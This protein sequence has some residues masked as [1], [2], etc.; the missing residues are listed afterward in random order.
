[1]NHE[2]EPEQRSE[3]ASDP[4][5]ERTPER[6]SGA[7]TEESY[8]TAAVL[9]EPAEHLFAAILGQRS[10]LSEELNEQ[11]KTLEPEIT[12]TD[13]AAPMIIDNVK[14]GQELKLNQPKA[15]GGKQDE[16]DGFIQDIQLY[17]AVNDNVYDSDKKKL[18]PS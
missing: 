10:P 1:M 18:C 8:H 2:T 5:I 3:T 14:K 16:L 17:L 12:E 15:F 6:A 11:P 13:M 4:E 7:D 9:S